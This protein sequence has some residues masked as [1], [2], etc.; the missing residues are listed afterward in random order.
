MLPEA[1]SRESL[2][3]GHGRDN[4]CLTFSAAVRADGSLGSVEVSPK[5]YTQAIHPKP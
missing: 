3:L 1:L 2:S 4:Y 5:P